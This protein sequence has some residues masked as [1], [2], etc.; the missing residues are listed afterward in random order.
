MYFLLAAFF[1]PDSPRMKLYDTDES[2]VRFARDCFA[3]FPKLDTKGLRV[4]LE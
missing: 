4:T 3:A 1:G 2:D